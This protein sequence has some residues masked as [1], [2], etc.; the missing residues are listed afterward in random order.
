M[1]AAMAPATI[2]VVSS[3]QWE[4]SEGSLRHA[5]G[6]CALP[7]VFSQ[8][9]SKGPRCGHAG[10]LLLPTGCRRCWVARALLPDG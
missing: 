8:A 10:A 9:K 4:A 5:H 6:S 1:V 2:G 7:V 3:A